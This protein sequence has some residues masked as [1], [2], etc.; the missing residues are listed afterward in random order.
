MLQ[1][2]IC[3]SMMTTGCHCHQLAKPVV[4]ST[5]SL[6]STDVL[7]VFNLLLKLELATGNVLSVSAPSLVT[8]VSVRGPL[9]FK[10]V[11]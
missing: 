2:A 10:M 5:P 9:I 11:K 3:P 6:L 1:F 4:C 7:F 8:P